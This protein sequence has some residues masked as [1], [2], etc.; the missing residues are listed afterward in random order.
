M[1]RHV[2]LTLGR[3]GSNTLRDLLNQHPEVFN[4]GEV[5]GPWTDPRKL[6]RRIPLI[7]QRDEAFLDWVLYS[8]AS[9]LG[10]WGVHRLNRLRGNGG[11][12]KRFGGIKS[13]GFKD[14][15]MNFDRC[16]LLSYF[17][18]RPDI[19]VI[20]LQRND[21][22][23]RMVSAELLNR[24]G[25]VRLSTDDSTEKARKPATLRFEP[26]EFVEKLSVIDAE[27]ALLETMLAELP[28]ENVLRIDYE[29]FY[30]DI[31]HRAAALRA[32]FEFL[33]LEPVETELRF[34]KIVRQPLRE[35]IE[36]FD[37]CLA[38][39]KGT[40]FADLMQEASEAD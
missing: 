26:G 29:D 40:R 19:K 6:Q 3:S 28:P 15:S 7:P 31:P 4:I 30:N 16:G 25:Q 14:F 8:R 11:P 24:T 23:A 38:A 33:G 12:H 22:L 21:I 36:N 37:D 35:V 17:K 20:G 10:C 13:F 1:N 39:T 9:Y 32:A 18:D 27:N 5:L 2:I 34:R